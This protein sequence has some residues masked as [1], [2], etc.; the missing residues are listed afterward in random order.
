MSACLVTLSAC[1]SMNSHF[2]CP[3][4]AG[5]NCKS[6]DRIDRMI[7]AGDIR[8][9][10]QTIKEDIKIAPVAEV[11]DNTTVKSCC[12][13]TSCRSDP[14]IR[15]GETI[16]RIWIAPYEDTE[17]NYHSDSLIYA[18]M[19]GGYWAKVPSIHTS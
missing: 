11:A 5:V 12:P 1:A 3:N 6:L 18:V 13:R 8:G 9:Q 15:Y 19:K 16:Q 10:T 2:D 7:D 4:Q 14:P 17:G